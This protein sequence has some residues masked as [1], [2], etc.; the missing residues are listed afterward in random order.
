MKFDLVAALEG[1]YGHETDGLL[2]L[3]GSLPEI[4]AKVAISLAKSRTVSPRI[5][6]SRR[7][8]YMYPEVAEI[9]VTDKNPLVLRNLLV[10]PW[11]PEH[12]RVMVALTT[13]N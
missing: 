5:A 4:S 6:L 2:G 12:I 1:S 8:C 13:R 9:L 7:D 11:C 10:N 3:L